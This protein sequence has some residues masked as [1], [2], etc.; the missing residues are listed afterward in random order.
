MGLVAFLKRHPVACLLL[1]T[2]GIPEYLSGSSPLDAIAFSP[3]T[4]LFQLAANLALYGPGVLLIREARVRWNKGG[5]TVLL[6]GA[7]YGILEEGVALSTLFNPAAGPVG[8]LGQYGHF[9]GVSWIWVAEILPVHMIYSIAVPI[10][11]LDLALPSTAGRGFLGGRKLA[12]A[13]GVLAADV[14]SLFLLILFGV[15]FWMGTPVLLGSLAAIGALAYAGWR[16]GPARIRPSSPAPSSGPATF[17]VVG[18]VFYPSVLILSSVLEGLR[19]P[20]AATLAAVVLLQAG[21]LK[22]VVSR[23]GSSG[24]QR[25]L[26][27]LS[28]GLILPIVT[29]GIASQ[30]VL[31]LPAAALAAGLWFFRKLWMRY[32]PVPARQAA[33]A[34][35]A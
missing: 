9:A 21:W 12:V 6:L 29:I 1:L 23:I 16:A 7:A 28:A 11:L 20:A 14:A 15:K 13:I 35:E 19:V 10:L 34:V 3:V 30:A 33:P 25:N 17:L 5:A 8:A 31:P 24:S 2:P 22:L 27:A 4:F 26:I 32:P 18:A